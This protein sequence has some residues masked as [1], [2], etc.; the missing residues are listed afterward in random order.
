M[1]KL[2]LINIVQTIIFIIISATDAVPVH[3]DYEG[4]F[5]KYYKSYHPRNGLNS[6]SSLLRDLAIYKRKLQL[7]GHYPVVYETAPGTLEQVYYPRQEL[8]AAAEL[9][10]DDVD[11]TEQGEYFIDINH[12]NNDN[13]KKDTKA[14]HIDGDD[15]YNNRNNN[16]K[17][18]KGP[19]IITENVGLD[20]LIDNQST[21]SLLNASSNRSEIKSEK[22]SSETTQSETLAE[23]SQLVE[24]KNKSSNDDTE[25]ESKSEEPQTSG[26]NSMTTTTEKVEIDVLRETKVNTT[27]KVDDSKTIVV[28]VNVITN[29]N[30]DGVHRPLHHHAHKIYENIDFGRKEM[31]TT[32]TT[33]T[34]APFQLFKPITLPKLNIFGKGTTTTQ[35]PL[36]TIAYQ[37]LGLEEDERPQSWFGYFRGLHDDY[38][39]KYQK[40]SSTTVGT[41]LKY[42]E[43]DIESTTEKDE[44]R[45]LL[46]ENELDASSVNENQEI[47][48]VTEEI[49]TDLVTEVK[50][51]TI[52]TET[53]TEFLTQ[54]PST[55]VFPEK[56][57][58][59]TTLK[60]ETTEKIVIET[61]KPEPT[62]EVTE[63]S[64]PETTTEKL[65]V[66]ETAPQNVSDTDEDSSRLLLTPETPEIEENLLTVTDS[67]KYDESFEEEN[68]TEID[69]TLLNE[70]FA[71]EYDQHVP[72]LVT[73]PPP[74][75]ENI[76]EETV[77]EEFTTEIEPE[78][79]EKS[80]EIDLTTEI[81]EK[82]EEITTEETKIDSEKEE[83]VEL[84]TEIDSTDENFSSELR[85]DFENGENETV[86]TLTN[87]IPTTSETPTT[88]SFS[89]TQYNWWQSLYNV[90]GWN[91][92]SQGTTTDY[93]E[94][95]ARN[96]EDSDV[97]E[98]LPTS[99]ENQLLKSLE[100]LD[101]KEIIN[102]ATDFLLKLKN[103]TQNEKPEVVEESEKNVKLILVDNSTE[104]VE[105]NLV[106]EEKNLFESNLN[107]NSTEN[108]EQNFFEE[109]EKN[110]LE[111]NL[112]ENLTENVEV[113]EPE[114]TFEPNLDEN[115]L[116]ESTENPIEFE[117]IE[118]LVEELELKTPDLTNDP[119]IEDE[120]FQ[121]DE[122]NEQTL[123]QTP[124]NENDED[125]DDDDY[126]E[127]NENIAALPP[128][129]ENIFQDVEN[130][131]HLKSLM[132][133]A[134][135]RLDD[136]S[137]TGPPVDFYEPSVA[138]ADENSNS[139]NDLE[140]LQLIPVIIEQLK[141][142][143][144]TPQEE[145]VLKSIFG[146]LWSI[147]VDEASRSEDVP[148]H[149]LLDILLK[150]N[151][152]KHNKRDV[153]YEND[154]AQN[155]VDLKERNMSPSDQLLHRT[156]SIV[157]RSM[158]QKNE[159]K[160]E[161]AQ[162]KIKQRKERKMRKMRNRRKQFSRV[163]ST[164]LLEPTNE[165]FAPAAN[166]APR[167]KRISRRHKRSFH[168]TRSDDLSRMKALVNYLNAH[169]DDNNEDDDDGSSEEV[170]FGYT[171][172][173][174]SYKKPTYNHPSIYEL[175][176]L[177]EQHRR[178]RQNKF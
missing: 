15:D 167:H 91:Y 36:V 54:T 30:H 87:E 11:V 3:E 166:F 150:S 143:S 140:V 157:S 41:E 152:V 88:P 115:S 59:T 65:F 119:L 46:I 42:D 118:N 56:N 16:Q 29:T 116:S 129:G 110:D 81:T 107:E 78:I 61:T 7:L 24:T 103:E 178:R 48:E 172:G 130:L 60:V 18:E 173:M 49:S 52:L 84:V 63:P 69:E 8:P 66:T 96:L 108:D 131:K 104:N 124:K 73:Y 121:I 28:T 50:S 128:M 111:P 174:E 62:E 53:T 101:L 68:P 100:Q 14:P 5:D 74:M 89:Q 144:V 4:E 135:D 37:P 163:S 77:D 168:I 21:I 23:T 93:P 162:R 102:N 106:E 177:A 92:S 109:P 26:I 19:Q 99:T 123:S 142:G 43:I 98:T 27:T 114:K 10:R 67:G 40:V 175:F 164:D 147:I 120:K 94:V 149:P 160:V 47:E 2:V 57:D 86:K 156:W 70:I 1:H 90:M 75:E 161:K 76:S 171:D 132:T 141:Q 95:K 45:K 136:K 97:N 127:S 176:H 25:N 137:V 39:K 146:D 32:T 85:L 38:K 79:T 58:E 170:S 12:N 148:I 158:L 71:Q 83:V 51:E 153:S 9:T 145:G 22:V 126:Q 112:N 125:Y 80:V 159:K 113:E 82:I 169:E 35:K 17:N 13:T 133:P 33:T 20:K 72:Y 154:V 31:P 105:P 139:F 138:A 151:E 155:T 165:V 44:M 34:K 117:K 134:R 55:K 6:Y 122:K 64:T